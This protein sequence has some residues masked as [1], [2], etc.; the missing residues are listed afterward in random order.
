M[1]C[2][3]F[4]GQ[5]VQYVG[6]GGKPKML[7]VSNIFYWTAEQNLGLPEKNQRKVGYYLNF[8]ECAIVV[9]EDDKYLI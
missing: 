2:K 5:R 1:K 6:F 9:H 3:Y 4:I 8:S 7:T